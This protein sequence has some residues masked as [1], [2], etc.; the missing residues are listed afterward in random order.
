VSRI[1]SMPTDF[2]TGATAWLL[3]KPV[4]GI[5]SSQFQLKVTVTSVAKTVTL[6]LRGTVN[7]TVYWGGSGTTAIE[8][9]YT[10][11]GDYS[12]TYS[13]AGTY[14]ISI[15]GTVTQFG[16]GVSTYSNADKITKVI[17]FGSVG[18]TSLSG[19]FNGATSL[20]SVPATQPGTVTNLSYMFKGA[21]SFN[22]AN[23]TGWNVSK[24]ADMSS[25]FYGATA[26]NQNISS[27]PIRKANTM[28]GMF[29]GVTISEPNYSALLT[30]WYSY[31]DTVRTITAFA[32]GG[33]SA[34]TVTTSTPHYFSVGDTVMISGTT[35]YNGRWKVT[36]VSGATQCTIAKS[37]VAETPSVSSTV[38][39]A[40]IRYVTFN[41]GNSAFSPGAATTARQNLISNLYWTITDGGSLPDLTTFYVPDMILSGRSFGVATEYTLAG[42]AHP[43]AGNV[44]LTVASGPGTL[45]GNTTAAAVNG[46]AG[47]SGLS[48]SAAGNYTLQASSSAMTSTS[49]S[50]KVYNYTAGGSGDG[51]TG[52]GIASYGLDGVPVFQWSGITSD[53]FTGS[54]WS[55][56]TTPSPSVLSERILI[57]PVAT[58]PVISGTT[59]NNLTLSSEL[60]VKDQATLTLNAGPVLTLSTDSRISTLGTTG[61]LVITSGASFLNYSTSSP[62]IEAHRAITGSKGWRLLSGP[63]KSTYSDLLSGFVSQGF[64]GATYASQQ[65]NFLWFDET[66]AGTTLQGWRKP[67]QMSDSTTTGRGYFLYVFNG[68]GKPSPLTGNYGDQLPITMNV[69]GNEPA[70]SASGYNFNVTRTFRQRTPSYT[71]GNAAGFIDVNLQDQGWNL[72]SNPTTSTI[73]WNASSGWTKTN[74][75]NSIY[76][77]DPSASSGNGAYLTWNGSVGDLGSGLIAPFQSF[78]IK[79]DSLPVLKM[80]NS[81]KTVG[82]TFRKVSSPDSAENFPSISLRLRSGD[83]LCDKFITFTPSGKLG[84]DDLDA[85]SLVPLSDTYVT[86]FSQSA[87]GQPSMKIQNL[88]LYG[89]EVPLIF[90]LYAGGFNSSTAING[91]FTLNWT[92]N[93]TVPDG[94]KIL[95]VDDGTKKAYPLTEAGSMEFSFATPASLYDRQAS[96]V[97][98]AKSEPGSLFEMP[99]HERNI[100]S[101]SNE[102][103]HIAARRTAAE[104]VKKMAKTTSAVVPELVSAQTVATEKEFDQT[105]DGGSGTT[106]SAGDSVLPAAVM[107]NPYPRVQRVMQKNSGSSLGKTSADENRFRI[108]VLPGREWDIEGY[109]PRT[110]EIHQNYPNP[111]NPATSIKFSVPKQTRVRLEVFNV[112]GQR[113]TTLADQ[114]FQAGFHTVTWNARG[115]ASGM[116][117]CRFAADKELKTI[118]MILLK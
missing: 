108:A 77:W 12:F 54:N 104:P 8:Q 5:C 107:V 97:G 92:F 110:P 13:S 43:F 64:T 37:Y 85:Y 68:A 47:F 14:I 28:A 115:V 102:V 51:H 66:D 55:R 22:S 95:L 3:A 31:S 72:I 75:G 105:Y 48:L 7:A 52:Y 69:I 56:G 62:R 81:V 84:L 50:F 79:A 27:W 103:Q 96:S 88:P 20:D 38:V 4:W 57:P 29:S 10:S 26:F 116:Y 63:V 11:A 25:M 59:A 71:P 76:V 9:T 111:F 39:L 89:Y 86:L 99:V 114:E 70:I 19:A 94:W 93:G 60:I 30:G 87:D 113:V 46:I 61:R 23:I 34:T 112:L 118:K 49:S 36:A 17:S 45:S 101:E 42:I 21:T 106:W 24:V 67:A 58:L 18:L 90:P 15:S 91:I 53:W 1:A 83:L 100:E 109:I 82:G 65:P 40:R 117:L 16:N 74:I 2:S 6:P 44:T 80:N 32:N 41:G 78:W 98:M 73:N 35:N 33:T